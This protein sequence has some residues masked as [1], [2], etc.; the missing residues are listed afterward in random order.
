[1]GRYFSSFQHGKIQ[2]WKLMWSGYYITKFLSTQLT[3][4]KLSPFSWLC[5][6][7]YY[8]FEVKIDLELDS[9]STHIHILSFKTLSFIYKEQIYSTWRKD[10]FIMMQA[11]CRHGRRQVHLLGLHQESRLHGH[12]CIIRI[13]YFKKYRRTYHALQVSKYF[14]YHR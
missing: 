7:T 10:S 9:Q 8:Y 13:Y 4:L 1:M 12:Y 5:P 11:L 6:F 3:Y 2:I 14:R